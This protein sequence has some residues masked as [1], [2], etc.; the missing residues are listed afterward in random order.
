M[1]KIDGQRLGALVTRIR[2]FGQGFGE[3]QADRLG[4]V[5]AELGGGAG[6]NACVQLAP[7]LLVATGQR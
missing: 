7:M 2:L 4:H 3:D 6:Q 1:G 5:W